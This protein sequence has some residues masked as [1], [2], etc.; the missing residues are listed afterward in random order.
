MP[1]RPSTTIIRHNVFAKADSVVN[2]APRPNV[3]VGHFPL[4]GPGA[5]DDYAIYGNLF[6]Q[7]RNE[8]LFQ[9]E[10]NVALYANL[11]V[12]DH[13][14]AI[15]IQP[16]NDIPRRILVAFNT[17]VA[18]GAGVTLSQKEGAPSYP[19]SVRANVVFAGVPIRGG[20]QSG[21]LAAAMSAA[22]EFLN[23]PFAALGE[24]DLYPRRRWPRMK[25]MN[26]ALKVPFPDGAK[27]FN[28][29]PR[30][31]GTLGAYSGVGTNPGWLPRLERKPE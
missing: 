21:N 23:R 11:F 25:S 10:G 1:T 26:T 12:N 3:L 30:L 5:E 14:D 31:P 17:V 20:E 28:G 8:A 16:H 24:L 22:G 15:R 2:D 7:N 9:G 27:D 4:A 6:Y 29:R 18:M 19:Q 13:G